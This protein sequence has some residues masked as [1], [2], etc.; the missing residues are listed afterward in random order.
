MYFPSL[1]QTWHARGKYT[2]ECNSVLEDI[3]CSHIHSRTNTHSHIATAVPVLNNNWFGLMMFFLGHLPFLLFLRSKFIF[4]RLSN[5]KLFVV[6]IFFPVA[7]PFNYQRNL[8]KNLGSKYSLNLF[9]T[10]LFMEMHNKD[11]LV[12]V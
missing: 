1:Y 8:N 5:A 7:I 9:P 3:K 4:F 2:V 10:I 6:G 11:W 12:V